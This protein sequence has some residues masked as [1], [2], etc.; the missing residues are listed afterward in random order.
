MIERLP[1]GE[2]ST[3]YRRRTQAGKDADAVTRLISE[4]RLHFAS[5]QEVADE[6]GITPER[7][8]CA[9]KLT[10]QPESHW[11]PVYRLDGAYI[12]VKHKRDLGAH[13]QHV[14]HN[15]RVAGGLHRSNLIAK[16]TMVGIAGASEAV[17]S[18]EEMLDV[19]VE[20]LSVRDLET[21]EELLM[22]HSMNGSSAG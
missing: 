15:S 14:K 7:V 8:D 21:F 13:E 22:E 18:I 20:E 6:I 9:M 3:Q 10:R 16:M 12:V 1:K 11:R 5:R 19:T 2:T 17:C 4:N